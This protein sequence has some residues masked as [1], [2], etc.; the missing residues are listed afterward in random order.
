MYCAHI[1]MSFGASNLSR[2][3]L[4]VVLVVA[5]F[6]RVLVLWLAVVQH[7]G[8]WLYTR[9]LEIG[10]VADSLLRNHG[11]ASPFGGD[12]GP[13]ALI[14][15]GYPLLVAGVFRVFG[16]YSV[17]SAMIIM[18]AQVAANLLT[19]ALMMKLANS[20]AGARA[21]LFA[22]LFWACW[23]PFLWMPTIFWETSL[24]SGILLG[25]LM[26]AQHVDR[27]PAAWKWL[28][29]G[30]FIGLAVLINMA[31]LITLT[32][33]FLW[34]AFRHLRTHTASLCMTVVI[35]ALT[36]SPWVLRNA[37]AFHAFVPLRT[38]VGLELWMGNH[39]GASGY[40]EE[41]LFPIYNSA[42]LQEYRRVGELRYDQEKSTTAKHWIAAHPAT[43]IELSVVRF[44][45]YWTGT[46]SRGGSPIFALGA[47]LTSIGGVAG[48][49]S[50][51]KRSEWHV[52]LLYCIPFIFFPL[53]YYITHAEFRYRLVLDPLLT[54]LTAY[55]F[56]A[57]ET[58]LGTSQTVDPELKQLV[59]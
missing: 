12:T 47:L 16:T 23:I 41:S 59:A 45:R 49:I 10:Y 38:T 9:G 54:V 44:F 8:T 32:G 57:S 5:L 30:L 58:A 1:L 53:P 26:F 21:A 20:L 55:A 7:G 39:D 31:L 56:C 33:V 11:F 29:F 43:F 34:L 25:M 2:R 36:F 24:S 27:R 50:L 22:G 18:G 15:P 37:K 19:I 48:L 42:E 51:Y 14:A 28:L 3:N 4:V 40:V 6:A 46:G 35:A 52:A 13:T 17:A